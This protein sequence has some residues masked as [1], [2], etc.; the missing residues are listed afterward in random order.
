VVLEVAALADLLAGGD[1]PAEGKGHKNG[2]APGVIEKEGASRGAE[3]GEVPGA[4]SDDANL[5]W[6][7][8]SDFPDNV[9]NSRDASSHDSA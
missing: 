1:W 2:V 5:P 7:H 8:L 9:V 3:E 6:R 4:V